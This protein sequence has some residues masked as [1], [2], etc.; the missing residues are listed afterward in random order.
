[1]EVETETQAFYRWEV[2][3]KPVAVHL[4]FGVVDRLLLEVMQ[5]FGSVPRRGAEVGGLLLGSVTAGEPAVVHV[6]D[7]E[8][9]FSEH[10]RGPS[11]L[12]SANDEARLVAAIERRS[13]GAA[14]PGLS[15]VGFFRSHTRDGLCLTEEDL[16]VFDRYFPNPA[17]VFLLVKPYAARASVGGFFF[18]EDGRIRTEAS[19]LEFPFRRRDLGGGVSAPMR[20]AEPEETLETEMPARRTTSLSLFGAGESLDPSRPSSLRVRSGMSGFR[21]PSSSFWSAWCWV[22]RRLSVSVRPSI[23]RRRATPICSRWPRPRPTARSNSAGIASR[24]LSS[25]LAAG[26]W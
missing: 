7:F 8:P 14:R 5:G 23:R 12:L 6:R 3:G 9:V 1:M 17:Q 2:A 10:A 21:S 22:S 18:R 24:Q 15:I 19:Y 25:R 11:Y 20:G 13:N 26:G 16:A 4:D